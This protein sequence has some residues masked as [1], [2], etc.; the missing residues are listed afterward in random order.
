MTFKKWIGRK[1][2]KLHG[3]T[4]DGQIPPEI[5]KCVVIEAPHTSMMDFVI[6]KMFFLSEG[7]P[8]FFLIK[9]ELFKI[10]LLG[11]I[12]KKMGGIPVDRSGHN[13]IVNDVTKAIKATDEIYIVMTPEGSRKLVT[14]WKRGFYYIAEKAE[15]PVIMGFINYKTKHCGYGPVLNLSGNFDEDWKIIEGFYRGMGA[16]YPEKFNLS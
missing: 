4:L 9:K 15:V 10:P 1:W 14:R 7:K 6:G 13:N 12:L 8:A 2:L 16:K 11:C 3:W 5:K